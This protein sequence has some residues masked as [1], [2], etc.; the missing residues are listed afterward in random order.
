[1]SM[2]RNEAPWA[3]ARPEAMTASLSL[4]LSLSLPTRVLG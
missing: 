4:S 2:A 3:P 1:M